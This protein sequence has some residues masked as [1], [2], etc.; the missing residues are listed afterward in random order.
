[1]E[2]NLL[3]GKTTSLTKAERETGYML[4]CL[5]LECTNTFPHVLGTLRY[6]CSKKCRLLARGSKKG[7]RIARRMNDE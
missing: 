6:F 2:E 4:K 1:M 3:E 5:R 7:K